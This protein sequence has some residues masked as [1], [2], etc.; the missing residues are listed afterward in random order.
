MKKLFYRI[1]KSKVYFRFTSIKKKQAK[2]MENLLEVKRQLNKWYD[3]PISWQLE[4][5]C[6][7]LEIRAN[8]PAYDFIIDL[9]MP[10]VD[11]EKEAKKIP[12]G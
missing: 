8:K 12:L 9:S 5:L 10:N 3:I 2:R 6:K 7:T 11:L 4:G 1:F